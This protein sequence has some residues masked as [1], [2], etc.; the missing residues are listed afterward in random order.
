MTLTRVKGI[1]PVGRFGD[2]GGDPGGGS[3]RGAP[4]AGGVDRKARRHPMRRL[5]AARLSVDLNFNHIGQ[6][7]R[8]G[9]QADRLEAERAITIIGKGRGYRVQHSRDTHAG[10]K[11]YLSYTSSSDTPDHIEVDLNFLFRAPYWYTRHQSDLSLRL[12][13]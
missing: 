5:L 7:D 10:R 2:P 11:I 4:T 8:A 6:E 1:G 12:H 9:M 13:P 3:G